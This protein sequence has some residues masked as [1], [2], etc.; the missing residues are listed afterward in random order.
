MAELYELESDELRRGY[1]QGTCNQQG[2]Y[3]VDPEGKPEKELTAKHQNR[4]EAVGA[5]VIP[6]LLDCCGIL[7]LATCPKPRAD[8]NCPG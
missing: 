6:D 7:Q 2:V 3:G 1:R 5:W 8:I 4:A